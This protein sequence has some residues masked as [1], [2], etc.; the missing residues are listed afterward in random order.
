MHLNTSIKTFNCYKD[1]DQNFWINRAQKEADLIFSKPGPR[2]GR[3]IN[4]VFDTVKFGH[5]SECW[6][7][8]EYGF[9]DD[10]RDYKDLIY[11]DV[12]IEVKTVRAKRN[13]SWML[14]KCNEEK[15]KPYRKFADIVYMFIGNEETGE[16]QF[17]NLYKWN[18]YRFS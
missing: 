1:L 13:V 14:K 18:G 10:T 8:S 3:P 6:L 11:N 12:P 4:E 5:A 17:E 9:T 16:Y 2:R 15:M 7:I